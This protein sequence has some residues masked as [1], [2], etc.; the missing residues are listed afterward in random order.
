MRNI[1]ENER[2]VFEKIA[3][4]FENDG[5]EFVAFEEIRIPADIGGYVPDFIAKKGDQYIAIEVKNHRTKAT[6][7]ALEHL[8]ERID[9]IPNWNFFYFFAEDEI[10]SDLMKAPSKESIET[11]IEE[12]Q[13]AARSGYTRSAF[14]LSWGLIEAIA[15][16][17]HSRIF[18]KPQTPGRI[19]TI[20]AENGV[21]TVD[22]AEKLRNLSRKRNALIHGRLEIEISMDDIDIMI[23]AVKNIGAGA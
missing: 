10:Q 19:I 4:R 9:A 21:F 7:R 11:T 17:A 1:S 3:P 22:E 6:Q 12:I 14:L 20:F 5:Y 15:R 23:D 16:N 8:K 13:A 18:G 2:L